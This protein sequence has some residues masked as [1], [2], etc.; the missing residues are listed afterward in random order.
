MQLYFVIN[1]TLN[2]VYCFCH[3]I[4]PA[5]L[6]AE[7]RDVTRAQ[8]SHHAP[9]ASS[10][11]VQHGTLEKEVFCYLNHPSSQ[12]LRDPGTKEARRQGKKVQRDDPKAPDFVS[13]LIAGY[14]TTR[15]AEQAA[16]NEQ[17]QSHRWNIPG[18]V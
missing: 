16:D 17:T 4:A 7:R 2:S 11:V 9:L 13:S 14:G 12:L 3:L 6:S 10:R 8:Y 18:C 1:T 15:L 5:A